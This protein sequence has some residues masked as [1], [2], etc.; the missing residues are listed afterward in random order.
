MVYRA[1]AR[2]IIAIVLLEP[3]AVGTTEVRQVS[4]QKQ[5]SINFEKF[6]KLGPYIRSLN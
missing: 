3:V 2:Y 6:I 4:N 5:N 1:D